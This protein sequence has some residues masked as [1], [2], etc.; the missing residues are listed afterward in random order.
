MYTLWPLI[1][2][3]ICIY[4]PWLI[5]AHSSTDVEWQVR[6]TYCDAALHHAI[7]MNIYIYRSPHPW[8]TAAHSST[9][10]APLRL[11]VGL[12]LL[13]RLALCSVYTHCNTTATHCNTLQLQRTATVPLHMTVGPPVQIGSVLCSVYV[14]C[15]T[16]QQ[17]F[18]IL[19]HTAARL[20][21]TVFNTRP[22]H[23]ANAAS[24]AVH[25][26]CNML[27]HAATPCN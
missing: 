27:Q 15:N 4:I 5:A 8:L 21:L 1:I 26:H 12:P 16:L 2:W 22:P 10:K 19:Q 20:Q 14:H 9:V 17:C 24:C 7:C 11:M 25:T 18:N 13:M 6:V 23:L 3:Y